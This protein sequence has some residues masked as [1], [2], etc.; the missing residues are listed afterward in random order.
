MHL[1]KEGGVLGILIAG[2]SDKPYGRGFVR[3]KQLTA[4]TASSRS[5]VLKEGDIILQVHV[6]TMM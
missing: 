1:S 2:G 4:N 3:I 5:G 6:Y